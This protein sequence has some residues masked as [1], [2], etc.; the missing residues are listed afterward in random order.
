MDKRLKVS[1][2][3]L[4]L[5]S[6]I[7]LASSG[8]TKG[9]ENVAKAEKYGAGAVVLKTKFQEELMSKSP[10]PR[11][12]IIN[13]GKKDYR[14]TTNMSYEQGYEFSIDEYCEEIKKCKENLDIK[15]IA[16]IGCSTKEYWEDWAKK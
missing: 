5:N 16:S 15:I 3:G 9:Y 11:F 8:I 1:Y 7:I 13:R 10:T 2:G 4:E 12:I 14:S 6:P